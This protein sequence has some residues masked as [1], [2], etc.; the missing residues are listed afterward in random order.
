MNQ[1]EFE[2]KLKRAI[3]YRI[4]GITNSMDNVLY[5]PQNIDVRICPKNGMSTLKWALLYCSGVDMETNQ[6]TA[7]AL[8]MGT[9]AHRILNIK[10]YGYREQLPYRKDSTRIA[11]TRDPVKRFLSAA[12]YIKKEYLRSQQTLDLNPESEDL[13]A[14]IESLSKMSDLDMLPDSLDDLIHGV[15][16]G[17]I[18][19]S[20]FFTQAY[21]MGNRSQYDKIYRIDRMPELLDYLRRAS[22]IHRAIDKIREN[23]TEPLYY[24]GVEKLTDTQ[25]R[26]IMKIYEE[27]YDYGWTE[28]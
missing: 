5:F 17:D 13:A 18:V 27:D 22:K 19:N 12:E 23:K 28:D 7:E 1:E 2:Q 24:G 6:K 11:V 25:K 26:R 14:K 9:K 20:H 16:E 3:Q 4:R 10:Q 15:R 21:Y 8:V